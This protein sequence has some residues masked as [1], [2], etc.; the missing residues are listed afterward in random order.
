[1]DRDQIFPGSGSLPPGRT[2][3]MKVDKKGNLFV[4]GPGGILVIAPE[5]EHLGTIG[6]PLP[7]S[8]LAFGPGERIAL[9][10]CPINRS[11]DQIKVAT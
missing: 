8:N 9:C 6:L 10:Y 1:M 7:P 5:G 4:T 11:K 2:D 3:G